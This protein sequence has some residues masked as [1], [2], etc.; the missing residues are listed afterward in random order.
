MTQA[1]TPPSDSVPDDSDNTKVRAESRLDQD[2]VS[3]WDR[4]LPESQVFEHPAALV[5]SLVDGTPL[6]SEDRVRHGV[7]TI[8]LEVWRL[9]ALSEAKDPGRWPPEVL[10]H[11][12]MS[13]NMAG[14]SLFNLGTGDMPR[15]ETSIA[16]AAGHLAFVPTES[17]VDR[18]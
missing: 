12:G 17:D 2:A 6:N 11:A 16:S 10:V 7:T 15:A 1:S 14:L 8:V 13:L 9:A 3:D 5:H 18:L 4:T